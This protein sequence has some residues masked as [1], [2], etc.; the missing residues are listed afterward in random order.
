MAAK[1]ES[2]FIHSVHKYLP[3]DVY[4]MKNFNQYNGGIAD[5]WYSGPGGDLWVEF[6]YVVLPAR[7]KTSIDLT[8]M[9]SALQVQWLGDRYVEG[10]NIAVVVGCKEGGV[11]FDRRMWE[12]PITAEAFRAAVVSRKEIAQ[13]ICEHTYG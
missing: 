11:W 4:R 10:R 7:P 13:Q 1:P 5:C 6:K 9:L 3:T 12:A 8:K 2:A